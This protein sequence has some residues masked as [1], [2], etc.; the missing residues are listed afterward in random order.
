MPYD[1]YVLWSPTG[2]RFY[3]GVSEDVAIRLAQHNDGIS[4]WTKRYA[5]TWQLVWQEQCPDLSAARSLESWL[6]RQKGGHG[7]W[8]RTGLNRSMFRLSGS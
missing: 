8:G 7:F 5:G 3:I 1:V 6:K 2:Q 4:K